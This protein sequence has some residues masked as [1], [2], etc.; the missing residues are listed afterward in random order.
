MRASSAST[1]A[2][3]RPPAAWARAAAGKKTQSARRNAEAPAHRHG[4][5]LVLGFFSDVV[6]TSP[7][8]PN[9]RLLWKPHC[10]LRMR[11]RRFCL[12][13]RLRAAPIARRS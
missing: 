12:A 2:S 11:R 9:A 13:N 3:L 7:I 6:G 5:A 10:S 8:P 4:W 1:P